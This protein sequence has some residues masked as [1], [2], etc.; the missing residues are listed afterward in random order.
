MLEGKS[1]IYSDRP[2]FPMLGETMG[3]DRGLVLSHYGERF[4]AFRRLLHRFMGTRSAVEH[5]HDVIARETCRLLARL[6][7]S[8]E[9]YIDHLRRYAVLDNYLSECIR[10]ISTSGLQVPL[11]SIWSTA[12]R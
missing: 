10:L 11:F 4:R 7:D 9:K 6:L 3:W 1:S 12:T 8:P 5:H 2:T